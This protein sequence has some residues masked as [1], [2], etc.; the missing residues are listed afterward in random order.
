MIAGSLIAGCGP[1]APPHTHTNLVEP[2]QRDPGAQAAAALARDAVHDNR[3]AYRTLYTWT[4]HEQIDELRK[5]RQLLTRDESPVSGAS[6]LD[7]VLYGLAQRGDPM[8]KLLYTTTF[9]RMRF[10]WPAAW[11]TRAGWPG[12]QYG[13]Q[14]IRVTLRP[15]AVI[16]ALFTATGTFE[17]RN[18]INEIVPI[19]SVLAKPE[20]IAAIYFVSDEDAPAVG[21]PRPGATFRE[22]ALCNEAMLES[23][24]VG[25][26]EIA[27][28]L[29]REAQTLD[30]VASYL[31]AQPSVTGTGTFL[32]SVWQRATSN[33]T[34]QVAYA[35]ALALASPLYQLDHL[36]VAKLAELLR[37]APK[38]RAFAV[39]AARPFAGVGAVRKPPRIVP[40]A[41]DTYASDS[42]PRPN[43]AARQLV[44]P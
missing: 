35:A 25:T 9:A 44:R 6:Y 16:V 37:R 34:L 28:E 21:F 12:E 26:P 8:A 20:T 1:S 27:A 41:G 31:A 18:L 33:P 29:E 14:L 43:T 23:W 17:A 11:P 32:P 36:R 24:E 15:E 30:L 7:Q 40:R 38:P 19:G 10:A 39:T 5:T 42:K 2:A 22:L 13:D 4:T 3:F